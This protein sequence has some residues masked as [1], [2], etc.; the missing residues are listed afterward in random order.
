MQT[1]QVV[2]GIADRRRSFAAIFS[3]YTSTAEGSVDNRFTV[4]RL[5]V[6]GPILRRRGR[7]RE[8]RIAAMPG[9][10]TR[11]GHDRPNECDKPASIGKTRRRHLRAYAIPSRYRA[12]PASFYGVIK[13]TVDYLPVTENAR[14]QLSYDT[15][16]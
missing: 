14:V 13:L 1:T 11:C 12:R 5:H 8:S 3:P 9:V 6:G 2:E 7:T 16:I 15:P 4:V 10:A